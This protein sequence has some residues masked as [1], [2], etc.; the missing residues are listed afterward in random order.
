MF[1]AWMPMISLVRYSPS[2]TTADALLEA[3]RKVTPSVRN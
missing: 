3:D 2:M 1:D